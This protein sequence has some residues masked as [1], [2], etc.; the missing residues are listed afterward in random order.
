MKTSLIKGVAIFAAGACCA[1]VVA[2][3][4]YNRLISPEEF[5]KEGDGLLLQVAEL[6]SHVVDVRE[7]TVWISAFPPDACFFPPPVPKQPVNGYVDARILERGYAAL[8]ALRLAKEVGNDT[9]VR[10]NDRCQVIPD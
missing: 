8:S 7:A 10:V 9:P 3:G 5:M 2:G 1:T 4:Y 6:G